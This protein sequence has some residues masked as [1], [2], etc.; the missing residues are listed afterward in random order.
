MEDTEQRK[1]AL[2]NCLKDQMK[3]PSNSSVTAT[4]SIQSRLALHENKNA[5][6]KT[7]KVEL[8]W[9]NY[10]DSMYKQVRMAAGG[11]TREIIVKKHEMVSSILERGKTLFSPGGTSMKGK[12]E[13]FECML[14]VTGNPL[15]VVSQSEV[16]ISKLP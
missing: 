3:L 6:K 5:E 1:T 2:I 15:M 11:G 7:R 16:C 10:Q 8:G 14:S 4:T 12:L 13:D 9:M